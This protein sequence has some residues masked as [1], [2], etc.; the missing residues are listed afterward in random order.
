MIPFFILFGIFGGFTT[1]VETAAI[2]VVYV[3]IV[4]VVVYK[5][6][7]WEEKEEDL[8]LEKNLNSSASYLYE[9][10]KAFSKWFRKKTKHAVIQK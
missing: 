5:D 4:E 9:E 6:I 8:K 7:S 1:L 10:K 3:I 2:I